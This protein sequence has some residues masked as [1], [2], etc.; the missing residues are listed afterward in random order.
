MIMKL[1][2]HFVSLLDE[3][4]N[5][6]KEINF[7][8]EKEVH[9]G[10]HLAQDLS[11]CQAAPVVLTSHNPSL[12]CYNRLEACLFSALLLTISYADMTEALSTAAAN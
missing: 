7:I 6:G 8:S 3:L 12:S 5:T 10:C 9:A 4:F 1:Q 11:E 2:Y